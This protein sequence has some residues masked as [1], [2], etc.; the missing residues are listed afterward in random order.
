MI[1]PQDLPPYLRGA[2]AHFGETR[3]ELVKKNPRN[4]IGCI[5][6]KYMYEAFLC[7]YETAFLVMPFIPHLPQ[8]Y[9]RIYVVPLVT[10]LRKIKIDYQLFSPKRF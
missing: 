10:C 1:F 2:F 9:K 5:P 7:C 6:G 4:L 3:V 8:L